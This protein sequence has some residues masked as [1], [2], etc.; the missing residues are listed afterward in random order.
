MRPSFDRGDSNIVY[1]LAKAWN[2]VYA[3]KKAGKN[4]T[5]ASL[6]RALNNMNTKADPFLPAGFV[7]KTGVKDAFPLEQLRMVKWGGG[8][9]GDWEAFGKLLNGI[10]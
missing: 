9:T 2:F 8:A 6:V 4:P 3:L 10:R 7:I 1:G 5:R